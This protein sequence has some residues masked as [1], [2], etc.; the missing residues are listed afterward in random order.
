MLARGKCNEEV[1]MPQFESPVGSTKEERS[2]SVLAGMW[3]TAWI[4]R[5]PFESHYEVTPGNW[6]YHTG[7]DLNLRM[8]QDEHKPV[9]AMGDG[10]I[11]YADI[12]P[13]PKVWGGLIV[14][15]H[16][17]VDGSVLYSRYAHVQA[18]DPAIFRKK[19]VKVTKG[20]PIAQIGGR[21]LGFDPHLHFDIST[22]S[23]LDG[24]HTAAGFWPK[25]NLNL[26]RQHFVDPL[27]WL[28]DH[29]HLNGE[30]HRVARVNLPANTA[31]WLVV[32]PD[33]VPVRKDHKISAA[34]LQ[35]LKPGSTIILKKGGG[36]LDGFLWGQISGGEFNGCWVTIQTVDKR[37]N[38]L[39][40]QP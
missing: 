15:C 20:Q 8:G 24:D 14:I 7:A 11:T 29:R 16:G 38:Y 22:T 30:S 1:K 39:S 28:F 2:A 34:P 9:Y 32:H 10:M 13:T 36:K 25:E 40:L 37:V 23:I 5:T 12:F 35:K 21:E 6:A 18:I 17:A 31:E 27:I 3:P 19:D 26:L 33:G 4:D